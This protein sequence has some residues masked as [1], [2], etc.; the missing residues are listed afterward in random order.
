MAIAL[1]VGALGAI[2]PMLVVG[3]ALPFALAWVQFGQGVWVP[4]VAPALAWTAAGGASFAVRARGEAR[5]QRQ[6]ASLFRRFSSSEVADEL[7]RERDAFM[8]GG[9]PKPRRVTLTALMSDL[10]G[11]TAAA[12]KLEP[13]R[14][15]AWIDAYMDA[16]TR[17]IEAHG[18]HVDDYVGDGIKA[19]FGVPIPSETESAIGSDARRAVA[20]AL[21]MGRGLERCNREWA[22]QGLPT[23]RQ[24]IGIATGPAVVGAIGSDA[25]MKYTSVGDTINTAARL[26][27]FAEPEAKIGDE[28]TSRILVGEATRARLGEGFVLEDLGVH[29]LK[30]KTEPLRIHRVV[31]ART[32]HA[33][34]REDGS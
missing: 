27:S 15:L 16:M 29:A 22:G 1:G 9:R 13:E 10:V 26:E 31:G 11:Y 24:R 12:E 25:R 8:E 30:G 4:A 5:A 6:L 28:P 19:N 7:W 34:R 18:G 17:I 14:L 20:C 3:A 21:A 33:D 23:A 32:A 2:V